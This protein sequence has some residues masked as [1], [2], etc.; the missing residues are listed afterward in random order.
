MGA[1]ITRR[2]GIRESFASHI[3]YSV[4]VGLARLTSTFET[5]ETIGQGSDPQGNVLP[6][7]DRYRI[8]ATTNEIRLEPTAEYWISN[9]FPLMI[10]LGPRIGYLA[11]GSYTQSERIISPAGAEFSDGTTLRNEHSGTMTEI[12][13]LQFGIN[14]GVAW[15]I[16]A[17]PNLALRPTLGATL[18]FT[19][20]VNGVEWKGTEFR[21]GVSVLYM[22]ESAQSTPL[23]NR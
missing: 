14:L 11:S 13:G 4:K 2:P 5:D 15:E 18:G 23:D 20:P 19:S 9:E 10:S 16:S 21:A 17:T 1:M 7:V 12:N 3:G 8:E 6:I 22:L